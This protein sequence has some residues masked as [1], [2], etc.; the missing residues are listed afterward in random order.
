MSKLSLRSNVTDRLLSVCEKKEVDLSDNYLGGELTL[1]AI[2]Q[3]IERI[4]FTS[5]LL[6]H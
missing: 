1:A 5:L 6:P 2:R 4:N 3:E